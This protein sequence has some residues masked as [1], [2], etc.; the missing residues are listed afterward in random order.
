MGWYR[1]GA[2]NLHRCPLFSLLGPARPRS[3]AQPRPCQNRRPPA[4]RDGLQPN[5]LH[6]LMVG[7][8]VVADVH[9]V[10]LEPRVVGVVATQPAMSPTG[11]IQLVCAQERAI[12]S[13]LHP[14]RGRTAPSAVAGGLRFTTPSNLGPRTLDLPNVSDTSVVSLRR[15][16]T[17]LSSTRSNPTAPKLAHLGDRGVR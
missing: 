8:H 16:R 4:R 5:V 15:S 6:P 12:T 1:H 14:I 7:H 3:P 9:L 10:R 17:D 11:I 2:F 13:V